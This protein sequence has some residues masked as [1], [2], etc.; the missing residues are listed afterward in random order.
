MIDSRNSSAISR[1]FSFWTNAFSPVQGPFCGLPATSTGN[2]LV[3]SCLFK[4]DCAVGRRFAEE[5]YG[6]EESLPSANTSKAE[7]INSVRASRGGHTFHERWAARRSLQLVFPQDKLIAIAIEGLSAHETAT[8]GPEAEDVADLVLYYGSGDTF[9]T[10]STAETVQFKYKVD[11]GVVTRSYLRKTIE[12]FAD[13]IAG[14]EKDFTAAEVD[15]KLRF[16]FVTNAEFAP[17]LWE[18]IEAIKSG[19]NP[20]KKT[21]VAADVAYLS[22]LCVKHSADPQRLF[23]RTE[24]RASTRNLPAQTGMLRRTLTDWSAGAD[25]SARIRLHGLTELVVEKAGPSGQGKNL[26]K[27]EDVLDALGCEPEDLFPAETRFID[28][29][30]VVER[31]QMAELIELVTRSN[32]PILIDAEGGV[33]KT[34]FVQS[35]AAKMAAQFEVVVFDCFG[36]GA[37]RSDDQARHLPKVGLVQITNELASRGLCDP[38]LPSDSDRIALVAAAR[39]RFAQAAKAVR[40]QSDREGILI[41]LDAADNAQLEADHRKEDAFPKLLLSS[42]DREPVEG[43]KLVLTARS[44]RKSGVVGRSKVEDFPL[45]PFSEEEARAF[46]SSRREH[47]SQVEFATAIMRSGRNARVLDYLVRTWDRNVAGDA[48]TSQITV[49]EIIAQQCRKIFDDLHIAGW[50]DAEITEFFAAISLLPPPIPLD[51]LANALGWSESQVNSA[52]SDLAPMLELAT[53]GA[54]FRDEPTE[55]YIRETY[56]EE[57]AA[58]QAIATRLFDCQRTS[59]YAAEALP[60]FLVIIN[61]RDRAYALANSPEFPSSVQSDYGRRRLTLARLFAA[62]RLGTNSGDLDRVLDL[63]MRLAQVAAANARGDQFIRNSPALATRLGDPDASRRLFNDRSGWRGARSARLTVHYAFAG[64]LDEARIQCQRTISWLNWHSQQKSGDNDPPHQ[65]GPGASDFAAVIFLSFVDGAYE[66]ADRNLANWNRRFAVNVSDEAIK[67]ARQYEHCTGNRVLDHLAEFVSAA[68][69]KSFALPVSLIRASVSP[70]TPRLLSMARAAGTAFAKTPPLALGEEPFDT[71]KMMEADVVLAA[72]SAFVHG[73]HCSAAAILATIGRMGPSGHDYNERWG[74]SRSWIPVLYRCVRAWSEGRSVRFHDLLPR[75]VKVNRQAK[76]ISSREELDK[77]LGGLTRSRPARSAA[78]PARKKKW[79]GKLPKQTGSELFSDSERTAIVTAIELIL[80]LIK[81]VE[82]GL[83]T[84]TKSI[85]ADHFHGYLEAWQA[86]LLTDVH[87]QAQEARDL[88]CRSIGLGLAKL[89]L[90][91]ARDIREADAKRLTEIVN[92]NGF[93]VSDKVSVLALLAE[94]PALHALC[95]SVARQIT[96]S[97]RADENIES[98]G[99]DYTALAEALLTMSVSE[100][101][102]YY[103]QGLS[104]L[105]QM[106]G[107]DHDLIYSLLHYAGEQQGG[108]IPPALGHRLMNLCQTIF[109]YEPRKFGWTL[110]SRAA[111]KSIGSFAMHKL[112]RWEDQDVADYSYGLP[113]LAC[114]LAKGCLLDPRRAAALL[115]ICEDHG[116]HEWQIGDGLR[117]VLGAADAKFHRL[118][119]VAVFEKL[120]AEHPFAAW[121]SLWVG[122]KGLSDRFPGI[123]S[124]EDKASLTGLA[125]EAQRK[126]DE[127]DAR[128]TPGN[129]SFAVVHQEGTEAD[130]ERLI[131]ELVD[132]C[133]PAAPIAIDDALKALEDRSRFPYFSRMRFF[134]RLRAKCFFDGRVAHL[135]ALCEASMLEADRAIDQIAEC[136]ELWRESSAY[137]SGQAKSIVEC[138]FQFKGS[139]LFELEYS[140]VSQRLK[141]LS[142]LCGD[143]QFVMLQV[144]QTVAQEQLELNGNEWLQLATSL[145]KDA[146]PAAS[147][148][149][150]ESLLS[151]PAA[152]LADE[153]GEGPF[154]VQYDPATSE[155][156]TIAD[157]FWH[158]L[159][160]PDA[161]VRWNVARAIKTLADL[162]LY[163]D[164]DALLDQFDRTEIPS[165]VSCDQ[166]LP[167]QN[168]RQWLLTGLARA[169][170]HHGGKLERLKPKLLALAERDDVHIIHKLHILR[171]LEHINDGRKAEPDIEVLRNALSQPAKGYRKTDKYPDYV[172]AQSEFR[173][174]YEFAKYEIAALA[175]L[176]GLAGGAATDAIAAEITRKWPEADGMSYFGGYDRYR[177]RSDRHEFY[178]EHI[179]RHGLLDTATSLLK[180]TPVV[181]RS[182]ESLNLSP[183]QEWIERYDITF[184]D[185]S[186]LSD[187]K[188][189]V[190]ACARAYLLGPRV[191]RQET[192]EVQEVLLT[193]L[194]L[195]P[196]VDDLVPIYAHWRSPD[197]VYVRMVTGLATPKGAVGQVTAFS[198][199]DDHNL[200]LPMFAGDGYDDRYRQKSPFEPFIWTPELHNI[201]VDEQD[202]IAARS[203]ARR[204]RLGIEPMSRLGLTADRE[205]RVWQTQ[206]GQLA[207]R[208]VAWGSWQP[209]PNHS[210]EQVH[211]DGEVLYADPVWLESALKKL[212]KRLV[213]SVTLSKYKSRHDYEGA[214]GVRGVYV[215]L[216]SR[217]TLSHVWYAKKAS[218]ATY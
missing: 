33:G 108:Q 52:A 155:S 189:D 186:W 156:A 147:R 164:L 210:R 152:R 11:G 36:G 159:G 124:D 58:Q 79:R 99:S 73:S 16:L 80:S 118:I 212:G 13:T 21:Q 28:V 114:F 145:C 1:P 209:D 153:I 205:D 23:A 51:E 63:C 41:I 148:N 165:L 137:L 218:T 29:G 184:K 54:I 188:D 175:R 180:S 70:G 50:S 35:V 38:L 172:E 22:D 208:S 185:G 125:T 211:D 27:R 177:D 216:R 67:L 142:D 60:R 128:N 83:L 149:A 176:F 198:K 200:W 42:L 107:D 215:G 169:A 46:L 7:V 113:Q 84:N 121:A 157:L 53:H 4:I 138:L 214:T 101:Q 190:P 71:E 151:G 161:Y 88:L 92:G 18:A 199:Q 32:A 182:Y 174:D 201:G 30:N 65:S 106:G 196:A 160:D 195:R 163:D 39:K 187:R 2:L 167:Y 97:I 127:L 117:D 202:Q 135:L 105:D 130:A 207:L 43:V 81:P 56:S 91:H 170:L 158:L 9:A 179:Q 171:C 5:L 217:G 143:S 111:A 126:T 102:A 154:K 109:H 89:L 173:F 90:Q 168:S 123:I 15:A 206:G 150:L 192:L 78:I 133:D 61:D 17:A 47:I 6:E 131:G 20:D 166:K 136:F 24:F 86:K 103:R 193:R 40:E 45:G 44:H 100:A 203:A 8:P 162:E 194:G 10:C 204:A 213:Y 19:R 31:A 82:A 139:Q 25:S 87:P 120:K 119:F 48:P 72:S 183:P 75:E 110:F 115:T 85:S 197:G 3:R 55:T 69:A 116:W 34:V 66:I 59:T 146:S 132:G 98:R 62:F 122:L 77:F 37:Y 95:G 112:V 49:E 129:E 134:E 104:E 57:R 76:A 68:K 93:L 64:E 14:Y 178:R 141:Q 181:L 144:L 12:K 140:N 94:R 74:Y 191:E 26:L 96:A